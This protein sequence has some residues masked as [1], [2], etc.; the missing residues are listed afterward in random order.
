MRIT[1]A[2]MRHHTRLDYRQ[3]QILSAKKLATGCVAFDFHLPQ[4]A[5]DAESSVDV[6]ADQEISVQEAETIL[7]NVGAYIKANK[8]HMT[9]IRKTFLREDAEVA[10]VPILEFF[11]KHFKSDL[12]MIPLLRDYTPVNKKFQKPVPGRSAH[13]RFLRDD[14]NLVLLNECNTSQQCPICL[15]KVEKWQDTAVSHK[16]VHYKKTS[17]PEGSSPS[18]QESKTNK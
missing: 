2:E 5:D 11:Y 6:V 9:G 18:D 4:T 8:A 7:Q 13:K 14:F 15:G 17:N 1:G 12:A 3:K 16:S 10:V